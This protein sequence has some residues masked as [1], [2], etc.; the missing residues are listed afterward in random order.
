MATAHERAVKN[1]A[2]KAKKSSKETKS[3]S[4]AFNYKQLGITQEAWNALGS[5]GQAAIAVHGS[6][7]IKAIDKNQPLPEVLDDKEMAKLWKEAEKDPTIQKTF[8]EELTT[9]KDYMAKNVDLIS[10]NFKTLTHQQQ[11]EYIDAKKTLETT[12]AQTGTA[13][14]G[15]RQQAANKLESSQADT[16]QSSQN[17]LKQNLQSIESAFEQRFGSK[18]LSELNLAGIGGYSGDLVGGT[19]TGPAYGN[20]AY[21]ATGGLTGTQETD[22]TAAKLQKQQDLAATAVQNIQLKNIQREKNLAKAYSKLT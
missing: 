10:S 4:K 3:G 7:L 6:Q 2:K 13:Y 20:T 21:A 5:E 11:Q 15:F 8:G 12:A 22:E 19:Y 16:I 1:A 9:A 17:E 18:N 14:S